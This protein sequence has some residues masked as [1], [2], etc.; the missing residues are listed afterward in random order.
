MRF[1]CQ[2][3]ITG[4]ALFASLIVA[5]PMVLPRDEV[6]SKTPDEFLAEL[7]LPAPSIMSKDFPK[8]MFSGRELTSVEPNKSGSID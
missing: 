7:T 2:A 1:L 3:L 8:T 4:I 6:T 5:A